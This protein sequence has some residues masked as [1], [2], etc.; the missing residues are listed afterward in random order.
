MIESPRTTQIAFFR[1]A[2][3]RR[4]TKSICARVRA[5]ENP[6]KPFVRTSFLGTRRSCLPSPGWR[7]FDTDDQKPNLWLGLQGSPVN[8][9]KKGRVCI[10]LQIYLARLPILWLARRVGSTTLVS[11][12]RR[13][14]TDPIDSPALQPA[15]DETSTCY[16][17]AAPKLWN[18]LPFTLKEHHI[19]AKFKRS[20]QDLFICKSF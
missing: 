2:T 8:I 18:D 1:F 13:L 10:S 16:L 9:A 15:S 17:I 19:R 6:M 20:Y 5:R 7:F 11:R 3:R 12:Y 14:E 4:G